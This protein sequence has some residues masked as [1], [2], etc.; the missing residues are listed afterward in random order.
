MIFAGI[1]RGGADE[2]FN[3]L[4]L[5]VQDNTEVHRVVLP[6]RAWDML[7]FAGQE[8]AEVLLRQSVRYCVKAESWQHSPA[9]D[10]PREVLPAMLEKYKLLEKPAGSKR[11]RRGTLDL[12][13]KHKEGH[14]GTRPS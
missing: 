7:Q 13:G 3:A 9:W 1:A 4:L 2:A 6:Y 8:Q 14:S 11:M 12:P 5:T 10:R